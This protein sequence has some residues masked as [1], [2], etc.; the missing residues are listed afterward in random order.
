M[1]CSENIGTSY[2]GF[3]LQVRQPD[4][5][6][7]AADRP[8]TGADYDGFVA[9]APST[10]HSRVHR[11]G[12]LLDFALACDR[13]SSPTDPQWTTTHDLAAAP[14]RSEEHTSELQSRENHVCR[15][16]LA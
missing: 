13:R 14:L 8:R 3:V 15:L 2:A 6:R 11:H 10:R 1:V 12:R 16:L 7:Q 4:P 9:A 5:G